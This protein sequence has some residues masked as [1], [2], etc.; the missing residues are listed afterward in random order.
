MRSCAK[1]RASR[2]SFEH[3]RTALAQLLH[4]AVEGAGDDA[5]EARHDHQTADGDQQHEVPQDGDHTQP[6]NGLRVGVV[7]VA[8]NL[9]GL[10][11]GAAK[12][13]L[14]LARLH[15]ERGGP[16]V[17]GVAQLAEPVAELAAGD[18]PLE[19]LG[20]QR[21]VTVHPGQRRHLLGV[22]G[23][24]RRLPERGLDRLLVQLQEELARAVVVLPRRVVLVAELAQLLPV[25][26]GR[27]DDAAAAL[28][29]LQQ[30]FLVDAAKNLAM[31][32]GHTIVLTATGA[33]VL[34]RIT[35]EYTV[36]G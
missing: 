18:D 4:L 10:G 36:C 34:S 19:P 28:D 21:I 9:Q 33:E 13:P 16:L 31:S 17:V 26:G 29:G 15:A 24:E 5:D 1:C 25:F 30:V 32:L 27:L 3:S 11:H 12:G 7:W 8:R 35:P 22:V 23:D 2:V 20:E 14:T 6:V